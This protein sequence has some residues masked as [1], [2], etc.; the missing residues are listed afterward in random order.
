MGAQMKSNKFIPNI[1]KQRKKTLL[2]Q[3]SNI[4]FKNLE[5]QIVP[6]LIPQE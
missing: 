2:I 6:F 4:I 3:L 5:K 1:L